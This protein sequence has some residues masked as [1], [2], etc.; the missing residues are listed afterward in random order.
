MTYALLLALLLSDTL[1]PGIAIKDEGV[2]KGQ[3]Q[4]LDCT[5]AGVTC[6]VSGQ[7]ATVNVAGGGGSYTLPGATISTLGGVIV[8]SRLS[9]SAGNVLSADVQAGT[10]T[11]PD[12]TNL[13]TGGLRL[14]GDL[15]G[16]AVSPTVPGLAGKQAAGSYS[17]VG[18]C[19]ANTWASTLGASAA[20]TCTQPAFSNIS[21]TAAVGQIPA[22]A[23]L[24]VAGA[25]ASANAVNGAVVSLATNV[26]GRLPLANLTDNDTT[27]NLCLVSGGA[28]GEP[29]YATCPGG[30]GGAPTTATYWTSSADAG[31]SA[32][33]NLGGLTS[34]L[35]KHTVAAGVSTPATAAS[36]TDY[37]P[38]TSGN[39][40]GLVYSTTATGAH[41]TYG[42]TS[43]TNQFPRSLA[44]TG[45][46]TC[47]SLALADFTPNLG[48]TTTVLHGN[49]AGQPTY[50]G[51][52]VADHTATGTP[53]ATTYYRGDNT[54]S[55]PS[56]GAGVGTLTRLTA[57]WASSATANTLGIVGAAGV[58]MTSPTY[59]AA[60]P[61]SGL[62]RILMTR[63]SAVNQPR[64]GIQ[65]SGTVT[66]ANIAAVIGLAGTLPA[67]TQ[68]LQ[69]TNALATAG[70]AA[71]CTA[72]VVTGGAARVFMD[73]IEIAGVM[74]ATGTIS[75]VMAPSA[76]AAHTA[77]IG[78]YCV[79]Y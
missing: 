33:V 72:N 40:T 17:G 15:G 50:A 61:Y 26:T 11:L 69:S 2:A 22:L 39:A 31:L 21:G 52:A 55:T 29:N 5:G 63:P 45:A 23:Y 28:G 74:N 59:A 75:L 34:G 12:A 27:A 65:S 54:W 68:A 73:R 44:A 57:T 62:C 64:Y 48:T 10:Y 47:A 78:S 7:T 46:A 18:A 67:E 24:P 36:G 43:C 71:G 6:S 51:I 35:L 9:I 32:E 1:R 76:A 13:V 4:I 79:W 30:G 66:T 58:P 19:A 14:T 77:Q 42:G 60:A 25:A 53:S 70:C 37:G 49:A 41:T 38:P 3:A 56:G 8:G 16:T 20:P